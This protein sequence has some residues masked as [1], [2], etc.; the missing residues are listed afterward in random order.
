MKILP[1]ILLGL[2][3]VSSCTLPLAAQETYA[4]TKLARMD[5][6][7]YLQPLPQDGVVPL[8]TI[9]GDFAKNET[10]A[11]G[12][13]G[14]QR[15]TVVGRVSAL[16]KGSG[17]NKVMVVTLQ[18]PA[19]SLPAVKA[20]FLYGSFPENSELQVSEDGSQAFLVRRD[21]S[22]NILGQQPYLS[23]GQKAAIRGDFKELKLGDIV[24][25]ACKLLPKER[26]Q[27]E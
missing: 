5:A 15:V 12:K 26:R 14:G 2:C 21:R 13:Y 8:A 4:P 10:A 9:A 3:A 17:E 16:S 23:V 20:D 6:A 25:T 11:S 24:L 7:A 1:N 27:G 18:D 22:G 19:A